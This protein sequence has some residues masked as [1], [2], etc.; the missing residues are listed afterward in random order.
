MH[1]WRKL[2]RHIKAGNRCSYWSNLLHTERV[3]GLAPARDDANVANEVVTRVWQTDWQNVVPV[4]DRS[5]QAQNCN[6][7]PVVTK[8]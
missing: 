7:V 8:I 1:S 5:V 6:V 3:I 2:V 4:D